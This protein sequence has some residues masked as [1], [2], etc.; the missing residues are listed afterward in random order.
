MKS[1]LTPERIDYLRMHYPTKSNAEIAAA[2]GVDKSW[3]YT[4]ARQ[5]GL[6]KSN[7]YIHNLRVHVGGMS[8]T[9]GKIKLTDDIVRRRTQARLKKHKTDYARILF[10]LNQKT[11]MKVRLEPV[12]KRLQRRYLVSRGYLIDNVK[13]IA[14]W[15]SDTKRSFIIERRGSKWYDFQPKESKDE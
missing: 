5:L 12:A 1:K 13:M 2:I 10:G 9:K 4:H 7:A 6:R 14:Y 15:T 8:P 3:V 11:R